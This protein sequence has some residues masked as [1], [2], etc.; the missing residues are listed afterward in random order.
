MMI[1]ENINKGAIE[2]R[3]EQLRDSIEVRVTVDRMDA[4]SST[5]TG[6]PGHNERLR[7]GKDAGT[8]RQAEL[9][10]RSD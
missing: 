3:C 10:S 4:T 9:W 5:A 2:E 8:P 6:A 7:E 1:D